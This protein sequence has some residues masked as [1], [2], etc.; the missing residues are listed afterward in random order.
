MTLDHSINCELH[1][2]IIVINIFTENELNFN[3]PLME[4]LC[5]NRELFQNLKD[6]ESIK[7]IIDSIC[8]HTVETEPIDPVAGGNKGNANFKAGG[9]IGRYRLNNRE[10]YLLRQND[11]EQNILHLAINVFKNYPNR[12]AIIFTLIETLKGYL[13]YH[14]WHHLCFVQRNN[15]NGIRNAGYTVFQNLYYLR[16]PMIIGPFDSNTVNYTTGQKC[17]EALSVY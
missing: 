8:Q 2:N 9:N 17:I 10:Y 7:L 6:I 15:R 5:Q 16:Y 3:T 14:S 12:L 13:T 4:T 11:N 1:E